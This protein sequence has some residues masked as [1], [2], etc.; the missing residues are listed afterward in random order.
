[1]RAILFF[2]NGTEEVEALTPLDYLRRAGVEV[3]FVGLDD[4]VQT[5]S[6]GI[7]I[8]TDISSTELDLS[9]HFDML[10]L[11]G[12]MPGTTNLEKSKIV[13]SLINKAIESSLYLAAICAAPSIY[14]KLGLLNGKSA[15]CYPGFEKYLTGAK[16]ENKKVVV[17]GKMITATGAGAAN[18]FAIEL[19]RALCGDD[20]ANEI[21]KSVR[22]L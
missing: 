10:I 5:G 17:D 22:F 13:Q 14:G 19:I 16:V 8:I 2:A 21:G 6:H 4:K 12:G 3:T 18:E 11:P 9:E 20:K 7:S 15:T 1:M